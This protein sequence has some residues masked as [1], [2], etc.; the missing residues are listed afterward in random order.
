MQEV[1]EDAGFILRRL[2]ASR[3]TLMSSSP[4]VHELAEQRYDTPR[5]SGDDVG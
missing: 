3:G 1:G 2:L 4:A 5:S